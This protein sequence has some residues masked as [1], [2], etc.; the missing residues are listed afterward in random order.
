MYKPFEQGIEV[1]GASMV[2]VIASLPSIPFIVEKYFKKADL[3]ASSEIKPE[4]WY[5]QEKWL[6]VF[7][8]NFYY[9]KCG[10]KIRIIHLWPTNRT[11]SKAKW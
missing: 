11:T 2:S 3:P 5:S 1:L 6:L 7:K 10:H 4:T 9:P 8:L